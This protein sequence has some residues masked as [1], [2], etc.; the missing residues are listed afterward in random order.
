ML[1]YGVLNEKILVG[2][3]VYYSCYTFLFT[4]LSCWFSKQTPSK[5]QIFS[6]T[7]YIYVFYITYIL[8]QFILVFA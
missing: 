3:C 4:N 1:I 8:M 6:V 7:P 2:S 5:I